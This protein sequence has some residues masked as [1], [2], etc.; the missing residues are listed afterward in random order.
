MEG[1][2]EDENSFEDEKSN[3]DKTISRKNATGSSRSLKNKGKVGF[4]NN[5]RTINKISSFCPEDINS[6]KQ[7]KSSKSMKK[8]SRNEKNS[9]M[10]ND[11]SIQNLNKTSGTCTSIFS[12]SSKDKFSIKD[13][14]EKRNEPI[15]LAC[16]FNYQ[17]I[18]IINKIKEY[19]KNNGAYCN[20]KGNQLR[21]NKANISIIIIIDKVPIKE[22]FFLY[23]K[24]RSKC[25]NNEKQSL[26]LINDL[27]IYLQ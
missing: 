3:N 16:I 24:I 14:I 9:I 6:Q 13:E 15:N 26:K 18:D 12:L 20:V 4:N 22:G 25:K 17:I 1:I 2:S 27:L 21:L 23:L 7:K 5:I 19:C 8:K 10:L 11:T